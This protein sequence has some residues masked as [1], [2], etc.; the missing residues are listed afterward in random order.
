[1]TPRVQGYL[2]VAITMCIWGGFTL[3]SRLNAQWHISPWDITALRF[4][5]AFLILMPILLYKKDT[6]FFMEEAVCSVGTDWRLRILL[7][8]VYSIFVCS[9]CP[10]RDFSQR[11]YSTNHCCSS[12]D[13]I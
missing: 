5:L 10:C 4:G 6:A 7:N 11:L 9:C 8:S 1:M 13:F 2:F 12:M 3:F